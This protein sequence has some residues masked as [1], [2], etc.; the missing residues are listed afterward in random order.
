MKNTNNVELVNHIMTSGS[1]P[2]GALNQAFIL[3]AIE[4]FSRQ[5]LESTTWP[6]NG[7]ITE[8]AWKACAEFNLKNLDRHY[9]QPCGTF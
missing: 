7:F 8:K 2:A 6:E 1:C 3:Q 4:H 5:V 9:N